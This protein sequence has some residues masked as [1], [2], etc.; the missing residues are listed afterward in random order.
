MYE[1]PAK[2]TSVHDGDTMNVDIDLGFGIWIANQ[3]VRLY[4]LNC[5]ELSTPAGQEAAQFA[6]EM[7]PPGMKCSVHTVKDKKEKYGRYLA[8][9]FLP[10]GTSFNEMLIATGRA[11]TWDGKGS[12]PV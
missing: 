11:K 10:D 5:P 7:L 8:T 4:G 6:K 9:V 1:Y 12:R 3:P 2:I